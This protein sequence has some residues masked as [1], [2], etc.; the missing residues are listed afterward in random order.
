MVLH[1]AI[2]G[3]LYQQAIIARVMRTLSITVSAGLTLVDALGCGAD[4]S[5]NQ[6]YA[7]AL[8]KVKAEIVSGQK[9]HTALTQTHLF[10]H[11]ALQLVSVGEKVGSLEEMLGKIAD[12]YD[13]EVTALVDNLSTLIE[14]V[15]LIVL[16]LVV[17]GFVLTMYLPIFQLG[18]VF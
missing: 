9:F 10:P 13:D 14:P 3:Q 7:N 15:M 8:Q 5:G 12:Y 11:V 18:T 1:I 2:I 16:G 6:V 17:G 4:V